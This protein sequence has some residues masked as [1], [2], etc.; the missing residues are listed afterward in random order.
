[1]GWDREDNKKYTGKL[2][3]IYVS[4]EEDW[5]V[6][7]YIDHYLET[8]GKDVSDKNRDILAAKLE[9]FPGK[10]P[11]K[12]TDLNEWLDKEYDLKPKK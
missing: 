3:R 11:H 6:E 5:E 12:R 9:L 2:D 4:D 8:R 1:M 10:A 7:Y